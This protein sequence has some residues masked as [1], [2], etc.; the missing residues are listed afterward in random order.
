VPATAWTGYGRFCPL[1]RALDI[2]G[3]RWTLVIVQ[4]LLKRPSRYGELRRRLPGIGT[5]VLTDRLRTLQAA[6]LVERDAGTVGGGVVYVLTDRGHGLQNALEAL[7]RWG[8]EFLIDPTADGTG[9]QHF[10]LSYVTGIEGLDAGEFELTI[11]D[12]PTTLR[13][14]NGHLAQTPGPAEQPEL[15]VRTSA[16]FM[17]RWAAGTATWD[18]GLAAGHVNVA[19]PLESWQRWQAATGYLLTLPGAIQ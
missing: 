7:R 4:E 11:D 16:A 1:A 18:D 9:V 8:V 15:T 14:A 3:E 13:F 5:T 12:V 19:G 6:G 10:N 17:D 2:V